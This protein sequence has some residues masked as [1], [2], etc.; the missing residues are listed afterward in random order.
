MAQITDIKIHK[1]VQKV[2]VFPVCL[3]ADF[4]TA[5]NIVLLQIITEKF[6]LK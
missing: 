6:M 3:K 2:R 5:L 4:M 1:N